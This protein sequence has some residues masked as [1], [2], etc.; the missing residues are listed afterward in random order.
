M[1]MSGG[2]ESSDIETAYI[3][4]AV[5]A[6]RWR[7]MRLH[8]APPFAARDALAA[9]GVDAAEPRLCAITNMP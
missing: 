1:A 3:S 5:G 8:G 4:G 7:G 9:V 6:G 2:L